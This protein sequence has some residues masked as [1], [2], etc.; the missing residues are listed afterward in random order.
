MPSHFL[1]TR[2]SWK[3]LVPR[4]GEACGAGVAPAEP[5]RN[6]AP[7]RRV[8][9]VHKPRGRPTCP[10]SVCDRR[11]VTAVVS[12]A[13][14][15]IAAMTSEELTHRPYQAQSWQILGARSASKLD[16]SHCARGELNAS[17]R[18]TFS[19]LPSPSSSTVA[20]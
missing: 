12:D 17:I 2:Q 20:R 18:L 3:L 6:L 1:M 13:F 16:L 8:K 11:T 9:V 19:M 4:E 5:I 7:Q 15:V 10:C 14:A